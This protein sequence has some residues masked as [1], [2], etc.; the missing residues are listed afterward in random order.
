MKPGRHIKKSQ[1]KITRAA[2]PGGISEIVELHRDAK[3]ILSLTNL[4]NLIAVNIFR[5][6]Y[7]LQKKK[8]RD[9]QYTTYRNRANYRTKQTVK[10][11]PTQEAQMG[12][13]QI[14]EDTH[15]FSRDL[16]RKNCKGH[17]SIEMGIRGFFVLMWD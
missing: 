2:G 15:M 6:S 14:Q 10:G 13:N 16:T 12:L 7:T 4:T 3:K 8:K 1:E 5:I 9:N 11:K 17:V